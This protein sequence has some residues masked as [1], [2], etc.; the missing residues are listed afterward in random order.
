M[1]LPPHEIVDLGVGR[2][3]VAARDQGIGGTDEPG[4]LGVVA[5]GF[6][7]TTGRDLA[8]ADMPRLPVRQWKLQIL[9]ATS[10][11]GPWRRGPPVDDDPAYAAVGKEPFRR[12]VRIDRLERQDVHSRSR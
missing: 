8:K 7:R 5:R 10:F 2:D 3:R 12:I 6:V 4:L 9:P 11:D 1:A